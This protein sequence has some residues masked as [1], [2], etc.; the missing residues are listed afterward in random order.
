MSVFDLFVGIDWGSELHQVCV[1]DGERRKLFEGGVEHTG[2][3]LLALSEKLLVLAGG[4]AGRLGVAIET[5]RGPVVETLLEKGLA[6]FAINPK[7]LD[8]FRDRHTVAGAKDDR[9]D[10]LVLADSLRT[11]RAAFRLVELGDPKLVELRE[12]SRL[13]SELKAERIALGNRLR[14][15]LQRYFPQILK[16]GSVYDDAWL[17]AL[18]ERAS[19]PKDAGRLSLAKLGSILRQHHIRRITPEEIRGILQSEPLHVAP[20]V[21]AACRRSIASLLP[22]LRLTHEQKLEV[23]REIGQLIE[24]LSAPDAEGK[25]EHRDASLLQSLPGLGKI[26]CATMLAEAGTAL[27]R[28]DYNTL[29]GLSGVAPVTRRSGKQL[30]VSMR[31]SCSKRLRNAVHH[32]A[33]QAANWDPYWRARYAA[34]RAKGH[35]HARAVRSLADR[36]LAVLVAMLKSGKPYDPT[37]KAAVPTAVEQSPLSVTP[38]LA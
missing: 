23:E 6:V 31:H 33:S 15:Q 25:V 4:D 22:R 17:W 5:P 11:D 8:R 35:Q 16:L 38:A 36:L 7:Q 3:A 13:Q 19:A 2:E 10:A 26:T 27:T 29:R 1:L 12:L 24:Q 30:L 34:L 14:E 28:R 37:R 32:W 20:G 21:E 18:L 9:R